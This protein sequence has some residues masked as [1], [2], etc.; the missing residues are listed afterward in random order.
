VSRSDQGLDR[1]F[2]ITWYGTSGATCEMHVAGSRYLAIG[3]EHCCSS[4]DGERGELRESST[5]EM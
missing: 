2:R 4:I 1:L 5:V 3:Q